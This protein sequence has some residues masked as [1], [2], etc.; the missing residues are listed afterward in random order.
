MA[1]SE[2]RRIT[3]FYLRVRLWLV[4]VLPLLVLEGFRQSAYSQLSPPP[5]DQVSITMQLSADLSLGGHATLRLEV[6]NPGQALVANYTV[7]LYLTEGLA[8][9]TMALPH[10]LYEPQWQQTIH[11]APQGSAQWL[12]PI[13]ILANAATWQGVA[14]VHEQEIV[15][16]LMLQIAGLDTLDSVTAPTGDYQ[17]PRP[18][19]VTCPPSAALLS[20][21]GSSVLSALSHYYG[22]KSPYYS[23]H[24]ICNR[25]PSG[26]IQ[27]VPN[28]VAETAPL[29]SD[30]DDF[31]H[32][33]ATLIGQTKHIFTFSTLHFKTHG[34]SGESNL[35]RHYLA[36]A[37]LALHQQTPLA[38]P[39]PLLRFMYADWDSVHDTEEEVLMDLT[40]LLAAEEPDS[41][42]WR[43]S[44]AVATIGEISLV[45]PSP[46]NHSKVAIQDYRQAVVGGM[47]WDL[48]YLTP[49]TL[50]TSVSPITHPLYDLSLHLEGDAA[51][52]A[53]VYLD[54]VWRRNIDPL[55]P[56]LGNDCKS[57]WPKSSLWAHDCPLDMVPAYAPNGN[58]L[59]DY[60]LAETA[61]VFG[62]G[63]GHTEWLPVGDTDVSA[64]M[65]VIAAFDAAIHTIYINQH[66][67]TLSEFALDFVPEVKEAILDAVLRGVS[68]KIGLSEP[69]AYSNLVE[70][71]AQVYE[72]LISSLYTEAVLYYANAPD[73]T[74]LIDDALCRLQVGTFHLD[75][76]PY[77][78]TDTHV[79][80]NHSK[81]FM[82]D[83]QAFYV[84]SQN[85][86]PGGIGSSATD[87]VVDLN[88]YGY[89]IDDAALAAQ[90]RTEYWEPLWRQTGARANLLQP[91]QLSDGY[92]C[93]DGE[94]IVAG[95]VFLPSIL[96]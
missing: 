1:I 5:H 92:F 59:P 58:T 13:S 66:Q 38:G 85:L 34:E 83:E 93:R 22:D 51:R 71:P 25:F 23:E 78:E 69:W 63:R 26:W 40:Y 67:L 6:D 37:V 9:G 82:V 12:L 7:Y 15:S 48:A 16:R 81:F 75:Y 28:V 91:P 57:S 42:R 79:Y 89:L 44:I 47:N 90:I 72:K 41:A 62:L 4:L 17:M 77:P 43:V 73:A 64:D 76:Y 84:G 56:H 39:Y 60:S 86:Y 27:D 68:V 29:T 3:V 95:R 8:I 30:A 21:V 45:T 24:T 50:D 18:P 10:D 19:N 52:A 96:R 88:E 2:V 36:P 65:A 55:F 20:P 46:W 70:T 94:V 87:V 74:A 61:H 33:A 14:L 80:P 11:L 32:L 54:R 35:T 53:G 31:Y 49:K